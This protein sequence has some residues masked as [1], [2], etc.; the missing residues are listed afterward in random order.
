MLK[1][2]AAEGLA[3]A[4]AELVREFRSCWCSEQPLPKIPDKTC[5]ITESILA[6]VSLLLHVRPIYE[7]DPRIAL[8]EI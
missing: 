1:K 6:T 8:L 3:G 4:V 2:G 5:T 7:L